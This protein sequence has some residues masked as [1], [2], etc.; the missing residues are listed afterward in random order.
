[1]EAAAAGRL[2]ISTPVGE[3]PYQASLGAGITAP[4]SP[5]E[6]KEFA[7]DRLRYYREHSVEYVEIC[8]QIQEK[9]KHLDWQYTIDGW[10]A[11]I[12]SATPAGGLPA[13][14]ASA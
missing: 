4:L 1:M 6:Y 14:A 9:A 12:Q 13:K 8:R 5:D 3:F 2:V 7:V 10:I 11:L